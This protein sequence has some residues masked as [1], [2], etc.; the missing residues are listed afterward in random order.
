M[1]KFILF[2]ITVA[3]ACT[4]Y[5]RDHAN[6]FTFGA[7]AGINASSFMMSKVN[8]EGIHNKMRVGFVLGLTAERYVNSF[9]TL[10]ADLLFS[11]QGSSTVWN[12]AGEDINIRTAVYN[13]NI[14]ITANIR[15][16]KGL[17]FKAGLQPGFKVGA[18]FKGNPLFSEIE[19]HGSYFNRF[20]L[21]I[22]VGLAYDFNV[23]RVEARYAIGTNNIFRGMPR[24]LAEARNSVFSV[25]FGVK[26]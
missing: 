4:G 21:S 11:Q 23:F 17:T 12:N 14:P 26:F 10:E 7:K 13:I 18:K 1:R 8:V 15:I 19:Q 22:P 25:T 24:L 9:F 20:D 2:I 6:R 3:M 16:V 5:S